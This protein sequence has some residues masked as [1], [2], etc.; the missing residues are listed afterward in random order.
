[1]IDTKLFEM[2]LN[3][4]S[5]WYITKI[6][7]SKET[8]QLDIWI[9]FHPGSTFECPKC[10]LDGCK[11][12]DTEEKTWRHLNF[13]QYRCDL[14][15]RTP[16]VSC[17]NCGIILVNVP[18]AR[19]RSGFSLLMESLIVIMSHDMPISKIA[20]LFGEDDGKIWR[21]VEHYINEAR[22]EEDYSDVQIIGVDETSSRK[23][24]NYVTVAVDLKSSKVIFATEGKDHTTLE[25]F[26][27]DFKEHNG[28]PNSITDIC[29]DLSKAFIKGVHENFPDAVHTFDRFHVMKL[30]GEAVDQVRRTEQKTQPIL[31]K[32]RFMCL[33]N[34]D[35]LTKSEGQKFALLS[36]MNLKTARA[37]RMK[38]GLKK[39]WNCL[40]IETANNLFNDW[41]FWATALSENQVISHTKSFSNILFFFHL[42]LFI[43]IIHWVRPEQP[44]DS[45]MIFYIT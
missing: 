41:Y 36:E 8:R 14:H 12:Y 30:V 33:K 26:S 1:M 19:Q 34:N 38:E 21:V 3:I 15:C 5:P 13:F 43:R 20:E 28:D 18:W 11:G 7:F 35:S 16:R 25:R 22:K 17:P 4:Q 37:Y 9:D 2:A 29:S 39:V 6:T 32:T 42:G 45:E 24:H 44:S 40:D 23:G 27:E 10:S 31:R